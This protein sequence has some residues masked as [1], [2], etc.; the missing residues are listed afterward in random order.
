MPGRPELPVATCDGH[1]VKP[2]S[3][4]GWGLAAALVA[5]A[6]VLVPSG[7]GIA[8]SGQV[9]TSS[10]S[11]DP[12]VITPNGKTLYVVRNYAGKAIPIDTAT[13]KAGKAIND[14]YFPFAIA[15]TPH[16]KAAYVTNVG[17]RGGVLHTFNPNPTATIK[18]DRAN[19]LATV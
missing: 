9:A 13:R 15:V 7:T 14:A 5:Y 19:H 10:T 11:F 16:G 6:A 3:Y 18:A 1:Q 8:A 12:M 17:L 2:A 4:A